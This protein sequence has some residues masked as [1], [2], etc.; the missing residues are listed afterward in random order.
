MA[1]KLDGLVKEF[2]SGKLAVNIKA[3]KFAGNTDKLNK[4]ERQHELLT[5]C[6][7]AMDDETREIITLKF[8]ER[9]RWFEVAELT[10]IAERTAQ[11]RY[12]TFKEK[13][14]YQYFLQSQ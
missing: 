8:K 4:Y 3:C 14:L 11:H 7:H 13:V 12:R 5:A 2:A 6:W 1:D 9:K 10:G